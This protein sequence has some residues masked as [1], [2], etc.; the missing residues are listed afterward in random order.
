MLRRV[1][2]DP[3]FHSLPQCQMIKIIVNISIKSVGGIHI[4]PDL[5]LTI[6]SDLMRSVGMLYPVLKSIYWI[7]IVPL[8]N[9][10]EKFGYRSEDTGAERRAEIFRGWGMG[11]A[12]QPEKRSAE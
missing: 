5:F 3:R 6:F 4:A 9:G 10:H 7:F 1:V 8:D 11:V 12:P 2:S